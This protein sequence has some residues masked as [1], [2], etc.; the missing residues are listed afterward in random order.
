VFDE[1]AIVN[2]GASAIP[3]SGVVQAQTLNGRTISAS[4]RYTF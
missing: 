4:L 1:I 2:I 3:A